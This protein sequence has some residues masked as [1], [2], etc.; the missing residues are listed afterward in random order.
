M[1]PNRMSIVTWRIR[2]TSQKK[3]KKTM[4]P[5]PILAGTWFS[6]YKCIYI[7]YIHIDTYRY[8]RIYYCNLSA[9][10]FVIVHL[11]IYLFTYLDFVCFRFG[12][13]S[14][15]FAYV[16]RQDMGI[17]YLHLVTSIECIVSATGDDRMYR[18][19]FFACKLP[20]ANITPSICSTC[21]YWIWFEHVL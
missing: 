14:A 15:Y 20:K 6:Y 1:D 7:I 5:D 18:H 17:N 8:V 9:Y 21:S 16:S 2:G 4:K 19:T 13:P 12:G 10:L 11:L 3:H